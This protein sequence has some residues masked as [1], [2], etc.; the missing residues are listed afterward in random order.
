[1]AELIVWFLA[2]A[3]FDIYAYFVLFRSPEIR[4]VGVVISSIIAGAVITVGW[5]N[6][7][8]MPV[9]SESTD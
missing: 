9:R 5:I 7:L 4:P 6:I 8:T 1:M 3:A 2:P